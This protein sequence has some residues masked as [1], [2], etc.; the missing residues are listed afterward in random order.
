MLEGALGEPAQ[1]TNFKKRWVDT[2][3][4]KDVP[5]CA[6]S[7]EQ[8]HTLVCIFAEERGTQ[9]SF[10]QFAYAILDL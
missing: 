5:M 1:V 3:P 10:E 6:L 7:A 4:M 2:C 8:Q 9:L